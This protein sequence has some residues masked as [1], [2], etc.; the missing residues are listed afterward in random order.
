MST[1]SDLVK[2]STSQY[3]LRNDREGLHQMMATIASEPGVIRI[4]IFNQEGKITY[5]T[6]PR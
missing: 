6:D 2:R 5:S 4:R 1:A 3:M